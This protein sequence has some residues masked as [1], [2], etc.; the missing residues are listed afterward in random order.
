MPSTIQLA[1]LRRWPR[2]WRL[3]PTG[4]SANPCASSVTTAR[5]GSR[6]GIR[7][8][9]PG[10]QERDRPGDPNNE[11]A[12]IHLPTVQRP[13]DE[14]SAQNYQ[15][16]TLRESGNRVKT[17]QGANHD[18]IALPKHR[19]ARKLSRFKATER[20]PRP[21]GPRI[22]RLTS[23]ARCGVE[24]GK[25]YRLMR[26]GELETI[27]GLRMTHALLGLKACLEQSEVE[28]RLDAIEQHVT[29]QATIR[30]V[31]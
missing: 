10:K 5:Q 9:H 15:S 4:H 2:R 14:I 16:P 6:F 7:S 1:T 28:R 13:C 12:H 31:A 3:I 25:L 29:A 23:V 20:E 27:E 22:A 19:Y 18:W 8:Q 24:I 17:S 21:R 26:R 30:R 11:L